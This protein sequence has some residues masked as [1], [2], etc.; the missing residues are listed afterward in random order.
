MNDIEIEKLRTYAFKIK[1]HNY[2]SKPF[3]KKFSD[4][5]IVAS[6]RYKRDLI[7]KSP[8]YRNKYSHL[9][10]YDA[11]IDFLLSQLEKQA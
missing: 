7:K 1:K 5:I 11:E 4:E 9:T 3:R 8:D 10:V 2:S 6:I